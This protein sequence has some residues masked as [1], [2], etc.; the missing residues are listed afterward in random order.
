MSSFFSFSISY[1]SFLSFSLLL[2]LFLIYI[3]LLLSCFTR[4]FASAMQLYIQT[5]SILP[6]EKIQ[7]FGMFDI[8][9]GWNE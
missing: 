5:R 3:D 4:P 7:E 9:V 1:V 2:F 6:V 8:H